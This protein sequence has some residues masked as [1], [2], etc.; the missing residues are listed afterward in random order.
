MVDLRK[1]LSQS[2]EGVWDVG[3]I[4][5]MRLDKYFMLLLSVPYQ[6]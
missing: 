6:K 2:L 1:W 4:M 5:L 3:M